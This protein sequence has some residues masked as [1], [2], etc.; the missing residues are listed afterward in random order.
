MVM[1]STRASIASRG[2]T[3]LRWLTAVEW[4]I[5]AV[6]AV[7]EAIAEASRQPDTATVGTLELVFA[8]R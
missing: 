8:T 1:A 5:R 7:V 6:F 2:I 4:F 3:K